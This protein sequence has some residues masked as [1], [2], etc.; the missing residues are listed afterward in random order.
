MSNENKK[1]G[2]PLGVNFIILAFLLIMGE[3]MLTACG[4]ITLKTK[5]PQQELKNQPAK[6]DK[7]KGENPATKSDKQYEAEGTDTTTDDDPE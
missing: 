7:Q 5:S 6:T 2:K 1:I 4:I 3:F